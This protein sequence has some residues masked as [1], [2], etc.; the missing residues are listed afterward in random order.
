MTS[1]YVITSTLRLTRP[2]SAFLLSRAFH[3]SRSLS[4][5]KASTNQV[6]GT[7]KD[8]LSEVPK[9]TIRLNAKNLPS[10][11]IEGYERPI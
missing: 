1:R 11:R 6:A 3:I 5:S 7:R 10:K 9:D 4:S 2:S 8:L